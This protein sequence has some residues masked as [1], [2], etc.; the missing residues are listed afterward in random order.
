MTDERVERKLAA[1]LAADVVGYSRLMGENETGTRARFNA[2]LNELIE[3]AI[4]SS[5]GRLIKT[6]GDGLL[7][8]FASVVD[9]V[10]CAVDI[11]KGLVERNADDP[12]DQ[13][14]DFRVGVNLGDVI[15]EGEDIHGDGVNIA[16]RLEGLAEPGGICVSSKVHE[17]IKGK[18]KLGFEDL[19]AQKVK[20]IA[21]PVMAYRVLLDP[22]D[23]GKMIPAKRAIIPSKRW[24]AG[25][26]AVVLVLLAAGIAWWQPWV[27]PASVIATDAKKL[28]IVVLPFDNLTDDKKQA[29]FADAITEDLITDLSR[30]RGAF[31]IAR[32]TSF[33]YKGK[34]VSAKDVASDLKVRYILEG[35]VRRSGEQ[36]RVNAQ[37]IDGE[38]GG[39]I[40]S[41]KFDRELKDVIALQSDITGHIAS[42]LRAELLEAENR[43]PKPA[44][45][46]AWDYAL[47]GTV[48]MHR[49]RL[50]AKAFLVAKEL[51]EKAL[52]L[53][54]NLALAWE[55]LASVHFA[56]ATREIPGVSVP[57]SSDL[58]LEA[59]QK[60]VSLAP[61]SSNAHR[62]LG[63]AFYWKGQGERALAACQ[64]A[65]NL[66]RNNDLAIVC[67]SR[68]NFVLGKLNESIRLIKK[69]QQLNPRFREWLKNFYIG[70]GLFHLGKYQEAAV[71]FTKAT[72][73]FPNHASIKLYLASSLAMDGRADEARVVL[74]EYTKLARGKRNTIEKLRADRGHI[75]PEF[76]SLATALRRMGM[77]ER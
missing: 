57:N 49:V 56:A 3:P 60:A 16:A 61:M 32:S 5:R 76:E 46:K 68:A 65:L 41:E 55:G 26:T 50:R 66:N 12:N 6:T 58:A 1:I 54:P 43:R 9:A 52:E 48:T 14:I 25:I 36:V 72:A 28:S 23:I 59:A 77:P 40:W 20:N 4:S 24:A 35:S 70:T 29:Y 33:T 45:L 11:Q 71:A 7:V 22:A 63:M 39:H 62:A 15:I 73:D 74:A 17:E 64:K 10:Q 31:V 47:Q 75:V 34:V 21:E 38:T 8:E 53:D 30:I 42:V 18:V 69:S 51:F 37:L 67:V 27:E 2:H 44:N 13:R 19:G